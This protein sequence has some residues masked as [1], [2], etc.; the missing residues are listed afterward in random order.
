MFVLGIH[1]RCFVAR[2]VLEVNQY[3]FVLI[4][5]PE[6]VYLATNDLSR[7]RLSERYL[8]LDG[9]GFAIG[10]LQPTIE[11][12]DGGDDLFHVRDD[13]VHHIA[14]ANAGGLLHILLV[15]KSRVIDGKDV[16]DAG[17]CSSFVFRLYIV[18]LNATIKVCQNLDVP[19]C[20]CHFREFA[21]REI[22]RLLTAIGMLRI[23]VMLVCRYC[24]NISCGTG[25]DVLIDRL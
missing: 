6:K 22:L 13:L 25:L 2:E 5:I 12:L 8:V 16:V 4:Q 7:K 17:A 11:L 15:R 1:N 14:I 9:K 21:G 20:K 23:Q 3:T 24:G 18:R 19:L 10:L